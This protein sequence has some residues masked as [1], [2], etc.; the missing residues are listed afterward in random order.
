MGLRTSLERKI[1]Q[2]FMKP[3]FTQLLAFFTVALLGSATVHAQNSRVI[4]TVLSRQDNTPLEGAIVRLL[5]TKI[6]T[7]TDER[8]HFQLSDVPSGTF[9]M[10]FSYLGFDDDTLSLVVKAASTNK[11]AV[12]L[13][14]QQIQIKTLEIQSSRTQ[15]LALINRIDVQLRPVSSSQE[16]LRMAPGVFIAQHAGGGKAEQ[17]F[18]RGFDIDH[19]TDLAIS[20]DGIPVNMVSHAHGQGYA[21]LHF[22]IPETVERLGIDKGPYSVKQGN[23]ATAG[24]I[25]FQTK[26]A[27][28]RNLVKLEGA[29]YNNYR[30]L[31]MLKIGGKSTKNNRAD[32]YIAGE[33]LYNR[34][35]F[36]LPQ[37]LHRIN[38]FAKY[39]KLISRNS[40]LTAS[41]SDFRSQWNASGQIPERA[42]ASGLITRWGSID[43]TEG[44]QTSRSNL[45][46]QLSSQLGHGWQLR[47]QAYA[48]RYTF[49]LYSNFTFFANDSV[50]GDQIRQTEQRWLYGYNGSLSKTMELFGKKFTPE[51][52]IG[53]RKDD[54]GTIG[55][56]HTR[57]R[58]FLN[59]V[60]QGRV[61]EW[62]GFGWVN[63]KLALSP[64]FD[65]GL[66]LRGDVLHFAYLDRMET[67]P[68]TKQAQKAILSPKLNLDY[69]VSDRLQLFAKAGSG[70]HS[71]DTRVVLGTNDFQILPRAIGSDVGAV[72][73]PAAGLLVQ[74]A[75]WGLAMAQEFVYVGD[76]GIV[77][78]SGKSK[79][80][81]VDLSARWQVANWLA[82]D[83]DV[84]IAHARGYDDAG[85]STYIPLAPW[86]TSTGG[87]TAQFTSNFRGSLRYRFLGNRAADEVWDLT[88]QGYCIVDAAANYTF[89]SRYTVGLS[90]V[91]LLNA[92]WKEAQFATT[93]RLITEPSPVTEIHYT[94]GSPFALKMSLSCNF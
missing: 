76:E 83:A 3:F 72:F 71:N 13:K 28:D 81:G 46:L 74:V 53:F 37:N 14:E 1:L 25:D 75:V 26:N 60:Q 11:I 19:G 70:F 86:M 33:Y 69:F 45:N 77:E 94:P 57:A 35:F 82:A 41:V 31:A 34:S 17:I 23:L 38:V 89:K 42:V 52:G 12:S 50:D 85:V 59:R 62:N 63:G 30:A 54:V 58:E 22:L 87:L 48:S 64:K 65:L 9:K 7:Q 84:N 20:T 24:S 43:P 49:N 36:E 88:A 29:M 18:M 80:V 21:D 10:V 5:E 40:L 93:S 51:A 4:G 6:G 73:K 79:R 15:G 55:L 8:G 27:L 61:N 66:G 68:Q 16:L 47:Q 91:N 90:A 44:G 39:R 78:P 92:K 2:P 67:N 32:A 56:Y